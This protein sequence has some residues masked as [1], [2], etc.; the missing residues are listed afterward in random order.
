MEFE[1]DESK[2]TQNLMKHEIDFVDAVGVL[3]DEEARTVEDP[4]SNEARWITLGADFLGRVLI[5]VWTE[6][7][8][9]IRIISARKASASERKN[10]GGSS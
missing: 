5:V 3:Y 6:R 10:Y 2:R 8:S 4:D 1:W 7:G 9:T